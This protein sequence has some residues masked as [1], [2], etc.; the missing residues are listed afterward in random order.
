MEVTAPDGRIWDVHR[1]IRWPRWR[2]FDVPFDPIDG[3]GMLTD[4]GGG[5]LGLIAAILLGILVAA[6]LALLIVF[7]LPLVLFAVEAV[8]IIAA[9]VALGRPWYV[10]AATDG[11]PPETRRWL[12]RG[13]RGSRRAVRE[14]ADELRRGVVAAPETVCPGLSRSG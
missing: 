1:E 8:I 10:V 13:L 6:L 14:V 4:C 5:V 7:F 9:A 11:P 3:I 2:R 12:V